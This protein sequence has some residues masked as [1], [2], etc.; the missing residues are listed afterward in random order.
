M[1]QKPRGR[2]VAPKKNTTSLKTLYAVIGVIALVGV[3]VLLNYLTAEE[4]SSETAD[5]AQPT[6][7]ATTPADDA[8]GAE[9]GGDMSDVDEGAIP[10]GKTDGGFYYK[11]DPD[12]PV[13]VIE[14]SDFECPACSYHT[15]NMVQDI[16][17]RYVK[18]GKAQLV[19]HDFPLSFHS[20]APK[21]S[22]AAHCAGEQGRF[23]EMHD[24]LFAEQETWVN[25]PSVDTFAS[26]AQQAGAD[27]ATFT[28][29]LEQGK[30]AE[31]IVKA[32]QE[33]QQAGIRA[34]P[35]F[36]VNGTFV[37]LQNVITAIEDAANQ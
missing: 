19:F 11:G 24:T 32:V 2:K 20:H 7:S 9:D 12:A 36:V 33:G 37:E 25:N 34:T 27:P 29:C 22:E 3:A 13:K 18:T 16:V 23:W 35:S 28:R 10:V 8:S 30:F 21:A 5:T 6:T 26:L 15:R 14:Y 4:T 31:K 1:S 17:R